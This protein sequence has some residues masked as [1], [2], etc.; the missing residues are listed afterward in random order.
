MALG[1]HLRRLTQ[2]RLALV[3]SLAA[4]VLAG[5]TGAYHVT[6]LPPG[7]SGRS[8]AAAGADTQILVDGPSPG[9]LDTRFGSEGFGWLETGGQ[10]LSGV[11][12][13]APVSDTIASMAKIPAR[14]I[15]FSSPETPLTAGEEGS[16][17][18]PA[19]KRWTLTVAAR[20][21][22]PIVDVYAQGPTRAGALALVAAAFTALSEYVTSPSAHGAFQLS[23]TQ[24]GHGLIVYTSGPASIG[25][26][27]V[28]CLAALL[29]CC[30]LTVV[31]DRWRRALAAPPRRAVAG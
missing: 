8:V 26:V 3:L 14:D 29:A 15:S 31:V 18:V 19:G 2:L 24:L 4:T 23:V 28:R 9:V 16:P 7:I 10:L 12:V 6:L 30:L 27:A 13:S 17:A 5:L 1:I 11:M 22:V 25:S 20:P 21:D